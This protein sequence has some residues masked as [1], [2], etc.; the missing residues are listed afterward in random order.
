MLQVLA[1]FHEHILGLYGF[2][3][4]EINVLLQKGIGRKDEIQLNPYPEI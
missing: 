2:K 1:S 4:S 3:A